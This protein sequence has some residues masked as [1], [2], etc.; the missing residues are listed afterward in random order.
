M[1][2]FSLRALS[3]RIWPRVEVAHIGALGNLLTSPWCIRR[4]NPEREWLIPALLKRAVLFVDLPHEDSRF[5][6][7]S[8]SRTRTCNHRI[9]SAVL[10][11]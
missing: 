2:P 6:L 8:E 10:C 1:S 11:H 9:N 7:C 4:H 3:S 5:P